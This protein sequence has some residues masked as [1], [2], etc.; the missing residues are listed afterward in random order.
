MSNETRR[1]L[2]A[3]VLVAAVVAALATFRASDPDL[4]FHFATG[5]AVAAMRA[6]PGTNVL[7]FTQPDHEWLLHQWAP[8]TL[9]ELVRARCG[10]AGVTIVKIVVVVLTWLV[11]FAASW[12]AAGSAR[13]ARYCA[14]LLTIGGAAA[15]AFRFVERPLIFTNL[16]MAIVLY[17]IVAY[18]TA[19]PI[20]R[21]RLLLLA[22]LTTVV[23]SHLHAGAVNVYAM[24]IVVAIGAALEPL[25]RRA[26]DRDPIAP[27]GRADA[28]AFATTAAVAFAVSAAT[29]ALYNPHGIRVLS[30][31]FAMIG[32]AYQAEH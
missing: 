22:G 30:V 11:V 25:A 6:V 29:L 2:A 3:A 18:P 5:R 10:I 16:A 13:S 9:F 19:S 20:A 14:V 27:A 28:L 4:G 31:P 17:A 12:R 7:A 15:S 8:A 26:L 1:A 21:R 23:A 24:L 32:D